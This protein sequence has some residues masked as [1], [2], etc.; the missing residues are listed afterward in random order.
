MSKRANTHGK[1]RQ[2]LYNEYES[3][4]W[5]CRKPNAAEIDHVVPWAQGGATNT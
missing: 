5:L 1:H 4:C 3:I 2:R